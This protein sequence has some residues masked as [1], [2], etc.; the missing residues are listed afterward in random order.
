MPIDKPMLTVTNAFFFAHCKAKSLCEELQKANALASPFE[1][2]VLMP[3][4]KQAAELELALENARIA[5]RQS[6]YSGS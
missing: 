6:P 1:S 3:M 4:I 2:L 5:R